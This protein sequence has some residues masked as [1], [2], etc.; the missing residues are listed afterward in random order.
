MSQAGTQV[1]RAEGNAKK[2]HVANASQ[3]HPSRKR[4]VTSYPPGLCA[5]HCRV[6]QPHTGG[7]RPMDDRSPRILGP[8]SIRLPELSKLHLERASC[9][10]LALAGYSRNLGR[11]GRGIC[12]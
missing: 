6:N 3:K 5:L 9:Q 11:R 10:P 12:K 7:P 1:Y 4:S 2:A 8:H